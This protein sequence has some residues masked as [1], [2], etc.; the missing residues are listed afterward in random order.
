MRVF[1]RQRQAGRPV[2]RQPSWPVSRDPSSEPKYFH[3]RESIDWESGTEGQRADEGG[4]P[5]RPG[6]GR[7]GGGS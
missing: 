1:P 2:Q 6:W 7:F 4:N 5:Q 3:Y